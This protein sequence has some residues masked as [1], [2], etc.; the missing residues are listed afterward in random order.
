MRGSP[1]CRPVRAPA[2]SPS[3]AST[4]G[5]CDATSTAISRAGMPRASQSPTRRATSAAAPATTVEPGDASTATDTS[6]PAPARASSASAVAASS[7]TAAITPAPAILVSSADR[8]QMTRTPSARVSTPATTAAATS[9]MEWPATP[10][11]STPCARHMAAS[12]Y[13]IGEQHRL[14]LA[15]A[16]HR[17]AGPDR[18]QDREPGLGADLLV[19]LGQCGGKRGVAGEQA[20]AHARPLRALAG[21]HPYRLAD[22][23][24]PDLTG[25]HAGVD[26]PRREGA[27]STGQLVPR[28]GDHAEPAAPVGPAAGQRVAGVAQRDSGAGPLEPVREPGRRGGQRIG[29]PGRNGV[30][31]RHGLLN[32]ARRRARGAVRRRA[33]AGGC[34]LQ[35]DVRVGAGK[36]ER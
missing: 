22:D 35:Q 32:D 1:G 8:R 9:P 20:A 33:R 34:L 31:L 25:R 30:H 19:G 6:P 13:C 15:T 18:R 29:G 26:L 5:E 16:G 4:C 3:S 28:T 7:S 23:A 11:G 10:A 12:A 17:L 2:R 27:Q 21:E 36:A 24:V 14:H